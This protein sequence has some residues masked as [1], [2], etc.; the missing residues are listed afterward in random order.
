MDLLS[1]I[2]PVG[3]IPGNVCGSWWKSPSTARLVNGWGRLQRSNGAERGRTGYPQIWYPE[4]KEWGRA[5]EE[6]G[7]GGGS[8]EEICTSWFHP[9]AAVQIVGW[10]AGGSSEVDDVLQF[11]VCRFSDIQAISSPYNRDVIIRWC[12]MNQH[13][14]VEPPY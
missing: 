10:N 14:D 6:A 11:S 13:L 12:G 9:S 4:E 7:T 2:W 1:W 8:D 3:W 5:E